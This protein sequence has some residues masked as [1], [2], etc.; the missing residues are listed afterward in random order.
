MLKKWSFK[1]NESII[2]NKDITFPKILDSNPTLKC[3]IHNV[4]SS[5][6][7]INLTVKVIIDSLKQETVNF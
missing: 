3:E 5:Q 6:T 2:V 7:C 4:S 1:L